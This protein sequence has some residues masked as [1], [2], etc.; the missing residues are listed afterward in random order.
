MAAEEAE[1]AVEAESAAVD[2]AEVVE[3]VMDTPDEPPLPVVVAE[4]AC[5]IV[6]TGRHS[7]QHNR[8]T[9]SSGGQ[10]LALS[11][12]RIFRARDRAVLKV[13]E[14]GSSAVYMG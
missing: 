6:S 3:A 8:T 5:P 2:E 12:R 9:G 10:P 13:S 11:S 14:V 1:E 7:R 4:V